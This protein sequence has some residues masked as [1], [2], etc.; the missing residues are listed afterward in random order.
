[1]TSFITFL[2]ATTKE[3]EKSD[4]MY[5]SDLFSPGN[6]ACIIFFIRDSVAKN[7]KIL[8]RIALYMPP[9]IKV[10]YGMQWEQVRM[11]VEQYKDLVGS[12]GATAMD[13]WNGNMSGKQ[14]LSD[15]GKNFAKGLGNA[16][17]SLFNINAS[18]Y[19]DKLFE[20]TLNPHQALLFKG[21]D[22]REFEFDF[23]LMARSKEE[24]EEIRTIIKWFKMA[25]HPD[26][27]DDNSRYL[28]YPNNFDIFLATPSYDQ[29]FNISTSV[30]S[31]I[32]VDYAGS[33]VQ[34]FFD[35]TNAPVDIRLTLTFKELEVLTKTRIEAGY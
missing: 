33:G 31:N 13:I 10:K 15:S 28:Q 18:E 1:M 12:V 22:F 19:V 3:P 27:A 16:V 32:S 26:K 17:D 8:K 11:N 4:A 21:V 23:Q 20:R 25:A 9:N 34:S 2:K 5:P 6:E 24:S 29:M 35:G 14:F 30:L 7:S